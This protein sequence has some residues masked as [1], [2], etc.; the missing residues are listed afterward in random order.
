MI[1]LCNE[2][3]SRKEGGKEG[4]KDRKKIREGKE[5]ERKGK[6]KGGLLKFVYGTI[7]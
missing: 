5:R 2:L 3:N 1:W 6:T 4:K 7:A